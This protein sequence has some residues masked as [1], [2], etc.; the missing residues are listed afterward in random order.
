MKKEAVLIGA[1]ERGRESSGAYAIRFPEKLKF[2]AVAEPDDNKRERFAQQ[3]GISDED[4][5]PCYEALFEKDRL[6]PL[7]FNT[8]MDRKHLDSSI[9]ALEKGYHLFLEKPMATDP[10]SCLRIFSQ[11]LKSRLMV[12]VCHPLRYT[13]FYKK[14]KELLDQGEIGEIVSF[15][16][17]ENVCY[18]HYA[19][20][21]VRGNW[22]RNDK[23][24]PFILTKCCHDMD[25]AAWL[26]GSPVKK[27]SSIGSLR[28][29]RGE[30]APEGAPERCTQG[31]PVEKECPFYAPA[32]YLGENTGW[33]VGAISG[34]TSLKARKEALEKSPYGRCVFRC[35]NNV[36]DHQLV[37]AEFPNGV[38]FNFAVRALSSY[39]YRSIRIVGT[40]GELRGHF[41]KGEIAITKFIPEY[42]W[43]YKP[44]IIEVKPDVGAHMG[45][46][47]GVINHFL[48]CFEEDDY[49][50]MK[51]SL[52]IALEGHMLSFAAEE[53]RTGS[54]ILSLKDFKSRFG[55]F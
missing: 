28:F 23:S 47:T 27:V 2:V 49:E 4:C 9:M 50:A 39:P 46:D 10:Q 40:K 18:W 22:A 1:G 5:F 37:N 54:N 51:S 14:V 25:I 20:S 21:F 16:M 53:A 15:T 33:P 12:Q 41:E 55:I 24:G 13:G 19:H 3:H 42:V 45:G 30:N 17:E 35:G 26:S 6:A 32:Y 34:D 29:F 8:T 48:R 36:A 7:C 31:C 44:E 43:S 38:M 52:K 11:A